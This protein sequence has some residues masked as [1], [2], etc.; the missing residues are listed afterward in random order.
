MSR[1]LSAREANQ[2]FSKVLADVERGETVRITKYG[3]TVAELRPVVDDRAN[4]PAW[5]AAFREM[6]DLMKAAPRTGYR[7]GEITEDDKYGEIYDRWPK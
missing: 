2:Q 7:V 5:R 3:R 4:D 6:I 1:V